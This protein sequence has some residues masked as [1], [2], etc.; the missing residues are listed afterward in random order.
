MVLGQGVRVY[1]RDHSDDSCAC[2]GKMAFTFQIQGGMEQR[3]PLVKL[4]SGRG[5]IRKI[6]WLDFAFGNTGIVLVETLLAT[7]SP[8]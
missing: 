5:E 1:R 2:H 4:P 3:L 6:W 7:M 8:L